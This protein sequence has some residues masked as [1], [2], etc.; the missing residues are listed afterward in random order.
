[1]L[2]GAYLCYEGFEKLAHKFLHRADEDEAHRAEL[3]QALGAL[4]ELSAYFL[5]P[6]AY[7]FIAIFLIAV[8]AWVWSAWDRHQLVEQ[9]TRKREVVMIEG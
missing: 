9:L 3:T 7:V 4:R 5:T 1:M 8:G 6:L 2:G